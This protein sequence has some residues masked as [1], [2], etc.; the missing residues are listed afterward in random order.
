MNSNYSLPE[1]GI[2]LRQKLFLIAGPCVIEGREHSFFMAAELKRIAAEAGI[3]FIFKASF[4]K[5][6][7]TSIQSFRGP[8]L[9]DGLQILKEIRGEIGVP[10]LSD[11]HTV[12]QAE[13]AAEVL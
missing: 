7:R 8:G 3:S 6:N 10:V 2:D 12:E 5:A 4:D 1:F 9:H 13:V 11:I